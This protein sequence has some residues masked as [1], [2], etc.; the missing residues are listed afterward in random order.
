MKKFKN[1]N[2]KSLDVADVGLYNPA[3]SIVVTVPFVSFE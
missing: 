1:Q 2:P 3:V